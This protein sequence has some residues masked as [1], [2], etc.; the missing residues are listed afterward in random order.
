MEEKNTKKLVRNFAIFIA[1]ILLTLWVLL[2][3]QSIED[4]LVVFRNVKVQFVILGIVAMFIYI[5]CDAINIKRNLKAL[6]KKTSLLQNIKYSL[7]GFFFSSITPAATGGQ[8]MQIYYMYK[9]GIVV[10]KSTATFLL[11]LAST[12]VVTI[13]LGLFALIFNY[14][15]M[16]N[17]LA[18]LF[19]IG[20][21]LNASAL[22]LLIIGI[23]SRRLSRGLINF[24]VKVLKLF[25]V[26]NVESKQNKMQNELLKYHKCSMLIRNRGGLLLRLMLTTIVQFI[27]YYSISYF[28]YKALGLSGHNAFEIITM[29]AIV[30]ATVSGIPSPGAV[31]VSEGAFI[32]I[33]SYIYPENMIK[34]ATLLHRSINFYLFVIISGITVLVNDLRVKKKLTDK[35][36]I[37]IEENNGGK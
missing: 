31:G 26:K 12:Q 6:G 13:A 30:F 32:Q 24:A 28:T 11:N 20:I 19:V 2:K 33:F 18:I 16:N 1:L 10:A 22:A 17:V 25:R 14:K 21:F 35:R 23:W 3:D 8:P 15:Y 5:L 29:Q 9:D 34:S 37:I 4:I 27:S 7:I 36:N